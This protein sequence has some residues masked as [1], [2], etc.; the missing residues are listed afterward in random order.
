VSGCK[1]HED[2]HEDCSDCRMKRLVE[3][4]RRESRDPSNCRCPILRAGDYCPVHN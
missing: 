1:K 2:F 3:Y 4:D